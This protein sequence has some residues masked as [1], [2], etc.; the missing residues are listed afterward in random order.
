M[1]RRPCGRGS[2]SPR[3]TP[4]SLPASPLRRPSST[5]RRSARTLHRRAPPGVGVEPICRVLTS[6]GLKIATSTY[7]AAKKRIASARTVRDTELKTQISGAH[8]DNLS[9]Y[10][11]RKLWQ[12]LHREGIPVA[13]CTVRDDGHELGR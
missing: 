9:V 2:V 13:R 11:V 3:S 12:H 8:T 1:P 4:A 6:Q 7:Y 10:G 5:G